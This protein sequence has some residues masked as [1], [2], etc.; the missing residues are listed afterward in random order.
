MMMC[1][2]FW[3]VVT[4]DT[5]ES[6]LINK[7]CVVVWME[8]KVQLYLGFVCKDIGDDRYLVEHLERH[9]PSQNYFWQ[10]PK[11]EDLQ[12]VFKV[13]I[14]PCRVME[15]RKYLHQQPHILIQIITLKTHNILKT[16]LLK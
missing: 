8:E 7:M 9:P 16:N 13:Q 3:I 11:V 14:L 10:H 5:Q 1:Q 4:E 12:T 15:F 6:S 2:S